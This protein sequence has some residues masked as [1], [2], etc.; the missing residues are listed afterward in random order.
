[1]LYAVSH[2][3]VARIG[4]GLSPE[5]ILI[6]P[7]GARAFVAVSGDDQ[8]AV[9]NLGTLKVTARF[10]TGPNSMPDGMAWAVRR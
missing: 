1:M 6:E 10:S 5:G 9:V 3:V 8:V 4:L 7:S 2:S